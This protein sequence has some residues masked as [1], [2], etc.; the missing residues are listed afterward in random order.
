MSRSSNQ[1]EPSS[2]ERTARGTEH[3]Q[4]PAHERVMPL[5]YD[6][7][8]AA[9]AVS[10]SET[11]IKN[12]IATGRLRIRKVGRRTIIPSQDLA[13]WLDEQPRSS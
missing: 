11:T 2:G 1:E 9:K 5:A 12:E 13:Q 6:I 4:Y 3:Q 10:L 7:P 8:T